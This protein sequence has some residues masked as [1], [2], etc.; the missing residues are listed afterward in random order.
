MEDPY[1]YLLDDRGQVAD[2]HLDDL[3]VE[4]IGGKLLFSPAG[5]AAEVYAS[6]SPTPA[7]QDAGRLVYTKTLR[8]AGQIGLPT[9]H[10]QEAVAVRNGVISLEDRQ[11][12]QS[13]ERLI[14]RQHKA[15]ENTRDPAQKVEFAAEIETLRVQVRELEL[16]EALVF[17]HT[18]EARADDARTGYLTSVCT[19]GGDLLSDPLW[20]SW[21]A[22]QGCDD[23]GLIEAATR[24][25]VRVAAGL[26]TR[27]IR[28][29]A[30]NPEW[31]LRWRSAKDTSSPPFDGH[32]SAWDRNKLNL[33][34]WSDFYDSVI[35][36]P[37][38]PSEE[39]VENDEL[40][41]QWLNEILAKK[42]QKQQ[43]SGGKAGPVIQ[44][45]G[46]GRRRVMERFGERTAAV[47]QPYRIRS[48]AGP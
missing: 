16:N 37:E 19:A 39:V 21:E 24:A 42:R 6:R 31:R 40:L 29:L 44:R 41:Q 27:V 30:R 14:D 18:A 48:Q 13:L 28:A 3:L 34:Y 43:R 46:T 10:E 11:R 25:H 26:P 23:Q 15:R 38:A 20:P 36:H 9:K 45:D 35:Q 22:F 8:E 33:I 5:R 17:A 32:S 4:V 12:K 47:N 2:D 1:A 7:E